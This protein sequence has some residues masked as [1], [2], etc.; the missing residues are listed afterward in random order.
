MSDSEHFHSEL[1]QTG[2]AAVGGTIELY[3]ETDT[4]N[5]LPSLPLP[6]T[7]FFESVF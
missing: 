7:I 5:I 3:H 4:E 2:V 1:P 6:S